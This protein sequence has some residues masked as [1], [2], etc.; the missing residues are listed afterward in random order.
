[1]TY[2]STCI[3]YMTLLTAAIMVIIDVLWLHRAA[4]RFGPWAMAEG[5]TPNVSPGDC[6]FF[7]QQGYT[8]IFDQVRMWHVTVSLII[9]KGCSTWNSNSVP[10][11]QPCVWA[12]GAAVTASKAAGRKASLLLTAAQPPSGTLERFAACPVGRIICQ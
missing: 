12:P 4:V 7:K 2:S 5:E 9:M 6:A 10:C 11:H 1:M 8:W 3:G